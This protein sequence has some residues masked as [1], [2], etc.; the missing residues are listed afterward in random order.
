M[1]LLVF[2]ITIDGCAHRPLPPGNPGWAQFERC[3]RSCEKHGPD[4]MGYDTC[5]VHDRKNPSCHEW[6]GVT[7]EE[8]LYDGDDES[9]GTE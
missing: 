7:R 5:K 3:I 8:L 1:F 9:E 6:E 2:T 4:L